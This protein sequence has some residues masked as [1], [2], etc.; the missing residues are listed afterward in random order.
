MA[1][2]LIL[3]YLENYLSMSG[4]QILLLEN[5]HQIKKIDH[6]YLILRKDLQSK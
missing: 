3:A 2:G 6:F 4:Q 5:Q 1:V